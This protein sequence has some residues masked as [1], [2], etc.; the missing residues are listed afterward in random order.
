MQC[1]VA[2]DHEDGTLKEEVEEGGV[3]EKEGQ[4]SGAES[5]LAR[6]LG[7]SIAP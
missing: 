3:R 2:V 7:L 6:V 4:Q 5:T 1:A